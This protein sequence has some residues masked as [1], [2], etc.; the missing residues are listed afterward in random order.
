MLLVDSNC[1]FQDQ[2]LLKC[3][4]VKMWNSMYQTTL[5]I[6]RGLHTEL[7]NLPRK[8]CKEDD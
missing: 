4:E 3:R 1:D 6:A 8:Y 7:Q 5:R 2:R